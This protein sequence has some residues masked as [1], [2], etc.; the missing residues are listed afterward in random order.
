MDTL[1]I[2]CGYL[3]LRVAREIRE[4]DPSAEIIGVTRTG[5]RHPELIAAGVKPILSD[6]ADERA[7]HTMVFPPRIVYSVAFDPTSGQSRG[8]VTH[9]GLARL[10]VKLTRELWTGRVV[11]ISSTGVY[12][13]TDGSWVDEH[14]PVDP[15]TQAGLD[16]IVAESVATRVNQQR[17][18]PLV[19]T[20]RLAG[21]YG[22]GRII[23][24]NGITRGDP[25]QGDPERWLNLIH[26]VD[27]ARVVVAAL[28]AD[29]PRELYVA[30]DNRPV[31][32]REYY[33]TL[34]RRLGAPAPRFLPNEA[35]E[36]D[37]RVR[38]TLMR[39]NLGILPQF[40]DFLAGL[41][42]ALWGE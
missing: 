10:V 39:E 30:C 2:G 11:N 32:R 35:A 17:A 42:D 15:T 28:I 3:G 4:L 22:P 40:P 1:I 9:D 20:I 23:G 6:V 8:S 31:Q 7:F 19:V 25:I 36:P 18:Q 27:A 41:D 5:R 13:Q 33:E 21:L 38:N 34:A 14:S 12:G 37:K 26:V 29:D 24:L 16:N